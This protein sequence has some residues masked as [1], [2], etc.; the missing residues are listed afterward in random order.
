MVFNVFIGNPLP[1]LE[2]VLFARG[3]PLVVGAVLVDYV[4]FAE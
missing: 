3:D 2:F 1:V 4:C